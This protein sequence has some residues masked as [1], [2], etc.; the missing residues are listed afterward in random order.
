MRCGCKVPGKMLLQAYLYTY[1][2]LRVLNFE[3]LPLSSYSFS[4]T[5]LALLGV[6]FGTPVVW[7]M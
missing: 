6:F 1:S 5:M 3:V 2:S 7:N 4:P